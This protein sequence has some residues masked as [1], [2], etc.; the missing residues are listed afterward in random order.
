MKSVR[1]SK[2]HRAGIS[3]KGDVADDKIPALLGDRVD[4]EGVNVDLIERSVNEEVKRFQNEP[5]KKKDF[6]ST[7]RR[8]SGAT[9]DGK[10][11]RT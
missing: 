6:R 3:C 11:S 10:T 5:L 2:V 9:A 1:G 8:S 7:S 4:D